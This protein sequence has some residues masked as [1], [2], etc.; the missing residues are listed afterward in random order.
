[1]P[2]SLKALVLGSAL[3]LT[4]ILLPTIS[5]TLSLSQAHAQ[6]TSFTASYT[7]K[8]LHIT[9]TITN[10]TIKVTPTISRFA[11]GLRGGM[12]NVAIQVAFE[13]VD[14]ILDPANNSI[15]INPKGGGL[16]VANGVFYG[17]TT[18][19]ACQKW[20]DSMNPIQSPSY[21]GVITK[22]TGEGNGGYCNVWGGPEK[23]T[24]NIGATWRKQVTITNADITQ[25][26]IIK[27]EQGNLQAQQL[28]TEIV[29]EQAKEG[30][31]DGEFERGFGITGASRIEEKEKSKTDD[32]GE[33]QS[34]DTTSNNCPNECRPYIDPIYYKMNSQSTYD[35]EKGVKQRYYELLLD[36]SHLYSRHKKVRN[37]H[38]RYGSWDG[39]ISKYIYTREELRVYVSMAQNT[40]NCE[41]YIPKEAYYWQSNPPPT[42]PNRSEANKAGYH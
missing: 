34:C 8:Q 39:H 9:H 4:P 31:Y 14:Y 10:S 28:L 36:N 38:P 16:Y 15:R 29:V 42:Q 23:Y 30:E 11:K 22:A 3:L 27:A 2:T 5:P 26:L 19:E 41:K 24:G 40:P 7:A 21:K 20:L 12:I 1:M 37:A 33:E 18:Q 6:T 25:Q 17:N 35:G 13:G 32:R